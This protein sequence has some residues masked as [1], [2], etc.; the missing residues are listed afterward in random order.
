[1]SLGFYFIRG[2]SYLV[3]RFVKYGLWF[4]LIKVCLETKVGVLIL[5]EEIKMYSLYKGAL[6]LK[7]IKID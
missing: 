4:S 3:Y 6:V 2:E 5:L 1:M 7:Q